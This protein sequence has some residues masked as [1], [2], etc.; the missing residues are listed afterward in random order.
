MGGPQDIKLAKRLGFITVDAGE[1]RLA[2]LNPALERILK[3]RSQAD[4][5]AFLKAFHKAA[6]RECHKVTLTLES[7]EPLS[8]EVKEKLVTSFK[9][10]REH[11]IHVEERI[12]PELIAGI[13]VR[14]GDTV[15]D[16]SLAHRLES[17]ASRIN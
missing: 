14:L 6:A 8:A 7:A 1:E 15:Y 4:R 13:R 2:E 17:L 12:N 10:E 9:K 11:R 3:G 16:G 5:K